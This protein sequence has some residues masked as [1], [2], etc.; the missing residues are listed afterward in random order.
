M[1]RAHRAPMSA[2]SSVRS[3]VRSFVR[4]HARTAAE[5]EEEAGRGSVSSSQWW[6]HS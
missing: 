1:I 6:R 5:E 3:F 2:G 4:L